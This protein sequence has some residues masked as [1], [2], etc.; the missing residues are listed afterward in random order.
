V[1]GAPPSAGEIVRTT[2]SGVAD[3]PRRRCAD[4]L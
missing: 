4:R 2:R 3:S 1:V